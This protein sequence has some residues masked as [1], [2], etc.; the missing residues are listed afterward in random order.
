M[1]IHINNCFS[2]GY[3][4]NTDEFMK[5]LCIRQY[6]S[7][8][9]YM[10]CDLETSIQFIENEFIDFLNVTYIPDHNFY[11]NGN[12]WDHKL[13]FN[14]RFKPYKYEG[15]INREKRVCVWNHHDL[16]NSIIADSIKRRYLRLLDADK[17]SNIL[18][19]YIENIQNYYTD[20]WENY[21]SKEI[22]LNFIANRT[23]RYILLLLP[24]INFNSDPVLYKINK[25]L[26]VI[27]YESNT[28]GTIND[29]DDPNIKW[30]KVQYLVLQNYSFDAHI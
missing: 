29:Y 14:N 8:F 1:A 12:K 25:Y 4:C 22:I 18:Y 27:F 3:R 30:N 6:S 13:Y 19:I 16:N 24:L 5:G 2:I 21:F 15:E 11:W 10:V 26:N 28:H 20:N 17:I 23:N 9:S 7:P